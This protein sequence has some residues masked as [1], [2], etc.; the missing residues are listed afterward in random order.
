LFPH[1]LNLR[2]I[3]AAGLDRHLGAYLIFLIALSMAGAARQGRTQA[4]ST[5][6]KN[7]MFVCLCKAQ[8][9]V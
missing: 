4:P 6:R 1:D 8:A 5:G 3:R 2:A 7:R 9:A